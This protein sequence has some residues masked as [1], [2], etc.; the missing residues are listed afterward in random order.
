MPKEEDGVQQIKQINEEVSLFQVT[1]NVTYTY[2]KKYVPS[3]V[4]LSLYTYMKMHYKYV[5]RSSLPVLYVKCY[6]NVCINK[7]SLNVDMIVRGRSL[8]YDIESRRENRLLSQ[9][10]GHVPSVFWACLQSFPFTSAKCPSST[11]SCDPQ[12]GVLVFVRV[13]GSSALARNRQ[14]VNNRWC[15][16]PEAKTPEGSLESAQT[17][18]Y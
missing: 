2:I 12:F 8:T 5:T 4:G 9:R 15:L 6:E 1:S 17:T 16:C 13:T 7:Y 14:A 3:S 18:R 11:N 10:V